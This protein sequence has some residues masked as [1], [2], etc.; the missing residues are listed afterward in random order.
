MIAVD[1]RGYETT[2][3]AFS[4]MAPLNHMFEWTKTFEGF[5]ANF[6]GVR[7]LDNCWYQY[8]AFRVLRELFRRVRRPMIF[9]GGSAGGFAAL[10]FGKRIGAD[11]IIAFCPQSA[12]GE[13]KRELGDHRWPGLCYSTP[14]RDIAGSYP[15][16]VVH[17]AA[18]EPE[19][20][21]HAMRLDARHCVWPS[22][23]HDLPYRLKESGDLRGLLMEATQ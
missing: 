14:S 16:A 20:V 13:A 21:I 10:W 15:Q 1:H 18:D 5:P 12:C 17:Y 23:G 6:V 7:D 19:D 2:V 3:V 22:G 8:N 4:G 11:R 9:I